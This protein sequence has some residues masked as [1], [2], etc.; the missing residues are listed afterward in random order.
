M[1]LKHPVAF[2]VEEQDTKSNPIVF[3]HD[4]AFAVFEAALADPE[5]LAKTAKHLMERNYQDAFLEKEKARERFGRTFLK[6]MSMLYSV[7]MGPDPRSIDDTAATYR[8]S[9]CHE[10]LTQFTYSTNGTLLNGKHHPT[11]LV[12]NLLAE[13]FM[14]VKT[15]E[16]LNRVTRE[17]KEKK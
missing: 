9:Q 13:F 6:T 16:T 2:V 10:C 11:C 4:E 12:G 8:V 7:D 3:P 14:W 5:R 15:D 17:L 1:S